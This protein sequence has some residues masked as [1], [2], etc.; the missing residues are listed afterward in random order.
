MKNAILLFVCFIT[1]AVLFSQPEFLNAWNYGG[2]LIDRGFGVLEDQTDNTWVI[3][4]ASQSGDGDLDGNDGDWDAWI[5]KVDFDGEI[6][7]NRR[8]AGSNSDIAYDLIPADDGGYLVGITSHSVDGDFANGN[9]ESTAWLV[10]FNN[11]GD[12]EWM[13]PF[14]GPEADSVRDLE[15][16]ADGN[17]LFVGAS[18]SEVGDLPGNEG[19]SDGWVCLLDQEG[20]LLESRNYG[21][22]QNDGIQQVSQDE[23]GN[24]LLVAESFSSDGDPGMNFGESDLWIFK[25]DLNGEIIWSQI[26]GGESY[27]VGPACAVNPSGISPDYV[28]TGS[29]NSNT[30]LFAGNQGGFDAFAIRLNSDGSLV[31]FRQYGGSATDYFEW[32]SFLSNQRLLMCGFS[33]SNDGDP[34]GNYGGADVWVLKT[35]ES[36]AITTSTIYG[37]SNNDFISAAYFS[38]DAEMIAV[39]GSESG[40]GILSGNFGEDDLLLF[41]LHPTFNGLSAKAKPNKT[42]LT[43]SPNPTSGFLQL[44]LNGEV[45]SVSGSCAMYDQQGRLV[46]REICSDGTI[47]VANLPAG[48]YTGLLTTEKRI[49]PF[50]FVK[51]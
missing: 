42:L 35:L 30:G 25:T 15:V 29:S 1:P 38:G 49:Y 5:L 21:G 45:F 18:N 3:V 8:L 23:E 47:S 46:L 19:L 9:A 16:L 40:D 36:G 43:T 11:N 26:I 17:I 48:M 31:W 39:G 13:K 33:Y 7:W 12:T 14:G 28:I 6:I 10:K 20:N 44:S 4:G 41:H 51:D 37:G 22:S 34:G 24:L 32:V 50:R 2:S 27:E